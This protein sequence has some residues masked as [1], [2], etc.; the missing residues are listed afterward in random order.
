MFTIRNVAPADYEMVKVLEDSLFKIH[1]QA[2][3]DYFH[4]QVQYTKQEFEDLLAL[5]SPISLAA[6]C[7]GQIAGICFGKIEQTPG[8]LFCKKRKIAVIEDLFTLPEYRRKGIASSLIE[9]ARELAIAQNA[10]ALELCV[11]DFNTSALHLY[12]KLGMQIQ[13]CRMEER[14]HDNSM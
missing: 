14:L 2:R 3:P 1:K 4:T 10:E 9:K 11:W 12:K 7:D 6:V 8:N 13:Y 5:P